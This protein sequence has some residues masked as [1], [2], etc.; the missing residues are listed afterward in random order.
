MTKSKNV[1]NDN[2]L[3]TVYGGT[4]SEVCELAG[5][6]ASKQGKFGYGAA[7]LLSVL[8]TF[9]LTSSASVANLLLKKV[10]GDALD[11]LNIK[12]DLSVGVA[13]TGFMSNANTYSRNGKTLYHTQ[14]LEI[15]KKEF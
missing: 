11:T 8:D 2:E 10:V 12:H 9:E 6:M 15:I 1:I 5:A 7:Q 4:L 14:V 3:N 13:G